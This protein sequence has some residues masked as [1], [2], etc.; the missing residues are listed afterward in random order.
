MNSGE[1]VKEDCPLKPLIGI[2]GRPDSANQNSVTCAQD[3]VWSV[4]RAG[5]LPTVIPFME[6][7]DNY[8]EILGRLDGL[9]LTG[10]A[11]VDPLHW[12]EEPGPRCGKIQPER[13]R[14]ELFLC[15]GALAIDLPL[16][17]ICRG[18]QVLAVAAGG[19]L[20]QDIPSQIPGSLKHFQ[21]APTWY[22][23][24]R[25]RLRNGT[26]LSSIFPSELRVNSFHHQSV[27][28]VPEGFVISAEAS[29]GVIEG[30]ESQGHC[31]AMGVQWHP[32]CMW[33]Q[34]FNY[35]PLFQAFVGASLERTASRA[36][37]ENGERGERSKSKKKR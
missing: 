32:E 36:R 1:N 2:T 11:D 20:V 23:T 25:V 6:I 30:I 26:R 27:K 22:P 18:V 17:G 15:R 21:E 8:R 3:Y 34:V 7:E 24:H 29:D 14:M 12:G 33:N 9:L 37:R 5:G 28:T 10:G 35:T 16:L 4:E 31:F 19:S 13:D